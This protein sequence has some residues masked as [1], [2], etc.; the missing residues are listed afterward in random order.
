M[1]TLAKLC[2]FPCRPMRPPHSGNAVTDLKRCISRK[3]EP[4]GVADVARLQVAPQELPNSGESGYPKVRHGAAIPGFGLAFHL[5]SHGFHHGL[6]A[7]ALSGAGCS[8]IGLH[9]L[10]ERL[11]P[12]SVRC[13]CE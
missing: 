9:Q 3:V 12:R 5:Q 4:V 7:V 11:Q 2:V 13:C 8:F 10:R 1:V 6:H